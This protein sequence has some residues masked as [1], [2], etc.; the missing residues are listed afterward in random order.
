[1]NRK[2]KRRKII[3]GND[4]LL[5]YE[6]GDFIKMDYNSFLCILQKDINMKEALDVL[7]NATG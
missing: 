6:N 5:E 3:Q 7:I 4:I 2:L 1:M